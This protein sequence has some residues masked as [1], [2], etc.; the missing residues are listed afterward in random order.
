MPKPVHEE[1]DVTALWNQAVYVEI[2][3]TANRPDIIIKNKKKREYMHTDRCGNARRQKYY[4]R[5]SGKEVK[6]KDF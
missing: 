1:R 6:I 3:V 2:E 5:G 4:A